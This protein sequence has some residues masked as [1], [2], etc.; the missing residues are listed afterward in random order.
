MK[1]IPHWLLILFTL[2]S[3]T[4]LSN[5]YADKTGTDG[6]FRSYHN[7]DLGFSLK[8]NTDYTLETTPLKWNAVDIHEPVKKM[9]KAELRK[10]KGELLFWGKTNVSP[11]YNTVGVVFPMIQETQVSN[12]R[13]NIALKD[14]KKSS[15]VIDERNVERSTYQLSGKD[16]DLGVVEYNTNIDSL[17]L[18]IYVTADNR[19]G[20]R[21]DDFVYASSKEQL[22]LHEASSLIEAYYKEA[23]KES[24]AAPP[25]SPFELARQ[26]F[27]STNANYLAPII[28]L[29]EQ[30]AFYD[31]IRLVDFYKQAMGTYQSFA[32]NPDSAVYFFDSRFNKNIKND[33]D[34]ID[35]TM[36]E[37]Y[38]LVSAEVAILEKSRL[39]KVVMVNE[40][41]HFPHHRSF[42][43]QLLGEFHELGFTH[44]GLEALSYDTEINEKGYPTIKSGFYTRE[45]SFGRMIRTALDLGFVVFPYENSKECENKNEDPY[46]CA[47]E[48]DR[49]QALNIAE[50][51]TRLPDARIL[52]LAGFQH[53]E[54]KSRTE[55]ITMAQHLKAI[56]GIDP[57]TINQT[58]MFGKSNTKYENTFYPYINQLFEVSEPS[59]LID[60][61]NNLWTNPESKGYYDI[62]VIYSRDQSNLKVKRGTSREIL[63]SNIEYPVIV[64]F[65]LKEEWKK[66]GY[67]AIPI[68]NEVIY[69]KPNSTPLS[70]KGYGEQVM[71]VRDIEGNA[72]YKK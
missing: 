32:G 61:D 12:Y 54:E 41:H 56:T 71:I 47:T 42:V 65:F 62:E 27:E 36:F 45:P 48:R 19:N 49:Q 35:E 31:S 64:Q 40:A 14:I 26:A 43:E 68:Y 38:H 17:S 20:F 39:E 25:F 15:V 44:L 2:L 29:H 50:V 1:L 21:E 66:D 53:I 9:L 3:C 37:G 57:L 5:K 34:S 16:I 24:R 28:K 63:P 10:N 6:L 23:D 55:W 58:A 70:I 33:K 30:K 52:I 69:K 7:V 46:Y 67:N 13:R 8:Y 51:I 59:V 18:K 22:L 72:L 11:F 4:P 60:Q